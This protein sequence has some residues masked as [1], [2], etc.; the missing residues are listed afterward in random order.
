MKNATI[1]ASFVYHAAMARR[2]GAAEGD[3]AAIEAGVRQP[4][5][6]ARSERSERRSNPVHRHGALLMVERTPLFA[7]GLPLA[8]CARSSQ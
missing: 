8:R 2:A 3:A 6:I 7:S 5:V 1:I 4:P